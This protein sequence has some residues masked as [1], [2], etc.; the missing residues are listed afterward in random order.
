MFQWENFGKLKYDNSV[1]SQDVL[2]STDGDVY[3]RVAQEPLKVTAEELDASIDARTKILVVGTGHY[4]TVKVTP[5]A[6]SFLKE[7]KIELVEKPTPEAVA[8][9]NKRMGV[10]GRKPAI[11]AI[12]YVK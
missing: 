7:L 9:Y 2:I 4:D 11:T 6:M 10:R 1:F 5:E 12:I 8:Y 3:E